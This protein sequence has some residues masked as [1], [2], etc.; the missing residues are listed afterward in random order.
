MTVPDRLQMILG[1]SVS[2]IV[3]KVGTL[4]PVLDLNFP[5]DKMI[6]L[7]SNDLFWAPLAGFEAPG[8]DRTTVQESTR[9]NQAFES[10]SLTQGVAYYLNTNRNMTIWTGITH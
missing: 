8:A 1:S 2:A 7:N 4:I 10:D 9:N 3:T 6:A 5:D